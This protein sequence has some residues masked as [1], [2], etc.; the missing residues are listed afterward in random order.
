MAILE[1]RS[2][3]S[4]PQPLAE[5]REDPD[6]SHW[7]AGKVVFPWFALSSL[8]LVLAFAGW[9]LVGSGTGDRRAGLG[10]AGDT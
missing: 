1:S 8:H 2:W 4:W 9:K 6:G 3:P 7:P 5:I 10:T